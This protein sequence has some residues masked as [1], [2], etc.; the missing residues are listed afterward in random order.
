MVERTRSHLLGLEDIEF[1]LSVEEAASLLGPRRT[2]AYEA[3]RRGE[4]P[5]HTLGHRVIVP[6]RALL[7]WLGVST[8]TA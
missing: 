7:E 5:C 1:R 2:A 6:V 8:L 4:L 3:D